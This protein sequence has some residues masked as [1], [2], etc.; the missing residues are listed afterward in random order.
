MLLKQGNIEGQTPF[1]LEGLFSDTAVF[2]H[3]L[4]AAQPAALNLKPSELYTK[5]RL[6]ARQRYSL[7]LPEKQSDLKCLQ[8]SANK[9]AVMRDVSLKL[10]VKLGNTRDFQLENDLT[11]A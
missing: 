3:L 8:N 10:G 2:K 5:L 6:V 1:H 11:S 4:P 7:A 9:L